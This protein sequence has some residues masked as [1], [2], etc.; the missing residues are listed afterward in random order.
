MKSIVKSLCLVL[1]EMF[2][3]SCCYVWV[4]QQGLRNCFETVEIL[5]NCCL[6]GELTLGATYM[7]VYICTNLGPKTLLANV[8]SLL[9]IMTNNNLCG[10]SVLMNS[11]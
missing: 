7:I 1:R 9:L 5:K 10:L 4:S 11:K 6:S 8:E 3:Q 2:Q